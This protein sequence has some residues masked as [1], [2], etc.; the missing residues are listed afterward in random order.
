MAL[1]SFLFERRQSMTPSRPYFVRAVYEWL[2][3]NSMTAHVVINAL[4]T[5]VQVPVQHVQDGRITLNIAPGA[6]RDLFIDNDGLSFSARFGGI[7]TN[8]YAPMQAVLA[9]YAR[10]NGQGMFFE[11]D[12]EFD[13][14]P[15]DSVGTAAKK[16]EPAPAPKRPGL[17]IVK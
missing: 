8:I 14:P 2:N 12:E 13:P 9:I 4:A 1:P 11:N 17:R 15:A 3:D 5:G 16:P 7:P 6:V 10:E